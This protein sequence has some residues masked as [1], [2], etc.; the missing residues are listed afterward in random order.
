MSNRFTIGTTAML[1]TGL[2]VSG[3]ATL[4]GLA[5]ASPQQ[6]KPAQAHPAGPSLPPSALHNAPPASV[7]AA[8]SDRA[9]TFYKR[10]WGIEIVGVRDVSSG[11]MLRFTYRVVDAKKAEA[12][13]DKR[14]NPYLID[15]KTGAKFAVPSMEQVGLL[16]QTATPEN[17]HLYWVIFGNPGG[18]VKPGNR[19]DVVI[20]AFRA[21]GLV[22]E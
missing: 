10:T 7:A 5:Q 14:W 16:R 13:N 18:W 17:G 22:V 9:N 15:E 6:D 21:D 12:L 19:V 4:T 1:L 20:G 3:I 2:L 8:R 11:S